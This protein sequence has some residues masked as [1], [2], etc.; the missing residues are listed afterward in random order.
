V[1][2]ETC[3]SRESNTGLAE[4]ALGKSQMATANF[5]TKPLK[6]REGATKACISRESNTGLAETEHSEERLATANFTT[7]PLKLLM[8][9]LNHA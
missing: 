6:R 1:Q 5:T 7:K 8:K 2:K 3:I 4:A 9:L